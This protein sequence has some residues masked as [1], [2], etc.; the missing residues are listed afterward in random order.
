MRRKTGKIYLWIEDIVELTGLS[1]SRAKKTHLTIRTALTP[2][3]SERI[4]KRITILEYARY[5]GED[6][7]HIYH[8]LRGESPPYNP[9]G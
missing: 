8:A 3:D 9:D 6:Y 1:Y 5:M 7:V 2:V 4:R